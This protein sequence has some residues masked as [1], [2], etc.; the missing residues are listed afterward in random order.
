M[1]LGQ[2]QLGGV[3]VP[4]NSDGGK[5]PGSWCGETWAAATHRDCDA[6]LSCPLSVTKVMVDFGFFFPPEKEPTCLSALT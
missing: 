2:V 4:I 1:D 5:C 6:L 3:C